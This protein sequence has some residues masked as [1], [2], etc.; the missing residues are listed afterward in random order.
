MKKIIKTITAV[1]AYN[2]LKDAKLTHMED[3]EKFAAIMA[4]R[5]LKKVATDY[6]DFAKDAQEKLKPENFGEIQEM[7]RRFGQLTD[8]EKLR[9]NSELRAYDERVE[10][11]VRPESLKEAEVEFEPL[12]KEAFSRLMKSNDLTA[13]TSLTL[14]DILCE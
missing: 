13:E 6:G 1:S 3:G 14:Y 12:S 2:V 10:K 11:C 8:E 5:P 9:V 4:M 7:A